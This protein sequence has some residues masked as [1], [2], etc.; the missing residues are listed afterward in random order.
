MLKSALFKKQK[1]INA[2]GLNYSL[3]KDREFIWLFLSKPTDEELNK[4][5]KDFQLDL[6]VLKNYTKATHSKRYTI[7]PFQ[8]VFVDYFMDK[9]SFKSTKLLF[10]LEK[11]FLI[12]IV[13]QHHDYYHDL[14]ERIV[15]EVDKKHNGE[16]SIYLLYHFLEE[17]T[18]E[19]YDVLANTEAKIVHLEESALRLGKSNVN[20]REIISLKR[21]LF[22]M[23]RRFWASAKIIFAIKKGLT[24]LVLNPDN[25]N[26]FDDIYHTFQHQIDIAM[27][28]K[29]MLSDAL[30]V[31]TASISNELATLSNNMNKTVKF[32]T[33]LTV[34]VMVP[35]LIASIYGMNFKYLPLANMDGGFYWM[36]GIMVLSLGL[37][38]GYFLKK[39][40]L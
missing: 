1:V 29:E 8:F 35:T 14:F 19:N 3:P 24:P 7:K 2:E 16:T 37:S 20:V 28:Q 17:D 21:E 31:H 39:D 26:L 40:W 13:S 9:G 18:E 6:K 4:L 11:Q 30:Q 15:K 34:I 10:I 12:T 38:A 32:L 23:T 5:V 22:L 33:A 36:L 27:A 25:A